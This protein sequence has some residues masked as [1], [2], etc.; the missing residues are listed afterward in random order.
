MDRYLV[1]AASGGA[2]A[3]KTPAAAKELIS[4]MAQNVQQFGT[5][6]NTPEKATNEVSVTATMDQQRI[7]NKL[8]ELASMV[9]QLALERKQP[10]Q[11]LCGICFLPSHPTD[12]CPQLQEN[13]ESV[14]GIF[15]G[16]PFQQHNQPFQQQPQ[17]KY[18]PYS[19][20]YNP[21]WRD[22]PN[23]RYG[24]SS[25][26]S[27]QQHPYQNH[28]LQQQ[29][30]QQPQRFNHPQGPSST[31]HAPPR[32]NQTM[33]PAQPPPKSEPSLDD[34][35]KQLAANTL[36]FQQRTETT[37]QN[38][39]TQIGQL[40][41]NINELRS[42]DSFI[43]PDC[44][45]ESDP[46]DA[47]SEIAAFLDNHD[48]EVENEHAYSDLHGS[49][50]EDIV[51]TNLA[52]IELEPNS[53]WVSPVQVVPKKTGIT[54]VPNERNE[55]VPMRVQ[56]SWRVCI[57]YRRLNLATKKDHFPLPFIDQMLER[58]AAPEDQEKATFT[59]PFGTFAYRR[60][61]F[62]L[63]N[64]PG[65][66]QRCM[67]SIFSDLLEHCMEVFV[68]DFSVYGTSF[69]D[70]IGIVLGHVVS[71][72]GIE[73]DKS[74]VDIISSLPYPI[75]VREIRSFLGHARFY[76]K[77]IQD[78]SKIARPLSNLLQKD[79]DFQFDEH[80]K[81]AFE[82]LKRRLTSPPIIQ[83][84]NWDFPFELMCDASNYAVGAVLSQR[85]EKKSYTN[86]QAEMSNRE[87][88]HILEKTVHPNRKDWSKRLEDA[89]WAYRTAFKTPIGMSPYR[90]VFGK[91]CHLPVEIEHKAYWKVKNCNMDLAHTDILVEPCGLPCFDIIPGM[92]ADIENGLVMC[93]F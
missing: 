82:E 21:G 88:K 92:E 29:Q 48:S 38:L 64:T 76:K 12:Q 41:S 60:M 61:P 89:L 59:C 11:Q 83:P 9:R 17:H 80:C 49:P 45:N 51:S 35:V 87:I 16:R 26:Q 74:K 91:A 24:G 34:I 47:C 28:N 5:R 23:F 39:E 73:V 42:Q 55:L 81:Q 36:Q 13:T 25:N 58:L 62:G 30:F 14:A 43:C 15:P 50:I 54:M 2:L 84:P 72:R 79:V 75:S 57:D 56:N 85:V 22:H 65:T 8:E 1:D 52:A 4:K 70:C 7:E 27:F 77:F 44:S 6:M 71:K 46:C 32:P 69:D 19:A 10:Q 93:W 40:A 78:F 90:L 67:V 31:N 37:I 68:D 20:T 66:F 63:C 33:Q 53:Q 3:E 18:D 86:G